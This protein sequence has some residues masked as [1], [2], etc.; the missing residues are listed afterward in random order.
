MI[1]NI[2]R[3]FDNFWFWRNHFSFTRLWLLIWMHKLLRLT[4]EIVRVLNHNRLNHTLLLKHL[5]LRIVEL[6]SVFDLVR[7]RLSKAVAFLAGERV[8]N[9]TRA[10]NNILSFHTTLV[11]IKDNYFKIIKFN[12]QI[13]FN[14]ASH[15][16]FLDFRR[17]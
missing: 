7:R 11:F 8:L 10:S 14:V 1:Q 3:A 6:S 13:K 15:R 12:H 2:H 9:Y 17:V 5:A 16:V 4:I